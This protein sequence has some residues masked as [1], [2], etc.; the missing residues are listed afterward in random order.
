MRVLMH[1]AENPG[2]AAHES[3]SEISSAEKPIHA[4][5]SDVINVLRC[6]VLLPT[7]K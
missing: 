3:G 7:V 1:C 2:Q 5:G 4:L 6:A